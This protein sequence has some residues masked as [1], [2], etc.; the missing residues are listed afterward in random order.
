MTKNI[1]IIGFGASGIMSFYNLVDKVA[2]NSLNI[3]IFDDEFKA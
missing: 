3:D 2:L 1:A